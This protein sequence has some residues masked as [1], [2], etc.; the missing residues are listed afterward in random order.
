[1]L[2]K[3][4]ELPAGE[5]AAELL[6]AIKRAQALFKEVESYYKRVLEETP[7]AIPGWILEPGD[8]RRSIEDTVSV[9]EKIESLL[10]LDEF[11]STC[12]VSVPQLERAW[13][14]KSG[15]LLGQA[16][17]PFKKFLGG[18][19]TEKRVASSLKPVLKTKQLANQ[20]DA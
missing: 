20:T 6:D 7:G 3:V 8:V 15:V 17:E 4:T 13:A 14:K 19:L 1:M 16:R 10:P 5:Q 11:L 9:R 12:S 2:A 18:L